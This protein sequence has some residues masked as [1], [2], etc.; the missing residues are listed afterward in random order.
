[1][2]KGQQK[3]KKKSEH[4]VCYFLLQVR[5]WLDVKDCRMFHQCHNISAIGGV[6]LQQTVDNGIVV[7]G[8]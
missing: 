7:A 8:S 1:M 6:S 5:S 4:S 2:M 3:K